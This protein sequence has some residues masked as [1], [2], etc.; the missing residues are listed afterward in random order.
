MEGIWRF[1]L[2]EVRRA[3]MRHLWF[4][5]DAWPAGVGYGVV[6][7]SGWVPDSWPVFL[8]FASAAAA[9]H[10]VGERRRAR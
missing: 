4:L 6:V 1:V 10:V 2:G 9:C 3:V 5:W 8:A 7:G